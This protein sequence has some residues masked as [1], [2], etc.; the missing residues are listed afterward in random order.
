M[1]FSNRLRRL[2]LLPHHHLIHLRRRHNHVTM[3][4]RPPRIFL[5]C[6]MIS[7]SLPWKTR[8]QSSLQFTCFHNIDIFALVT[9]G[10]HSHAN[11]S[12]I[13]PQIAW[14]YKINSGDYPNVCANWCYYVYCKSSRVIGVHKEFHRRCIGKTPSIIGLSRLTAKLTAGPNLNAADLTVAV[15]G[16]VG[17]ASLEMA[18]L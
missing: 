2:L 4:N 12:D 1:C 5:R 17:P 7:H 6:Q 15:V 9:S 18:A 14:L 3:T 11:A 16:G 10:D 8:C 13:S